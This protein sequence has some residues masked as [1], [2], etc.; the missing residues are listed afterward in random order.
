MHS[1]YVD[2]FSFSK[3]GPYYVILTA[4]KHIEIHL[5]L[6]LGCWD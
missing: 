2:F 1:H 3:I 5:S 4:L 6:H